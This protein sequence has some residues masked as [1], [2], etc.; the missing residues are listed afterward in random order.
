MGLTQFAIIGEEMSLLG[1]FSIIL[2]FVL[3][4]LKGCTI[5]I[6]TEDPFGSYLAFGITMMI[7]IQ[8]LINICVATGLLP[9]KGLAL[10]FLSYG[11]SSLFTNM[12]G[13]GMLSSIAKERRGR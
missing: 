6:K 4:A 2:L 12:L 13:M 7:I 1:V 10:P 11:G 5:A 3:L 9:T 8:V